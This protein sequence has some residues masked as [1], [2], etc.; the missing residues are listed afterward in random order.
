MARKI[1]SVEEQDFIKKN[2][3][4]MTIRKI[5]E[6]LGVD[7]EKTN[8]KIQHM[9][10]TNQLNIGKRRRK[11]KIGWKKYEPYIIKNYKNMTWAEMAK[12]LKL[13]YVTLYK[14]AEMMK[15]Q[16]KIGSKEQG[17]SQL[18]KP[19]RLSLQIAELDGN[20]ELGR[21]Y[22]IEK[23]KTAEKFDIKK[24]VG[25]LIQI[26]DRFYVFQNNARTESFLKIDFII[27][28]YSIKEV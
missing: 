22:H 4:K 15:K 8:Q 28:E 19:T 23:L 14:H 9:K 2:H 17:T 11:I 26:T 6:S 7:Y 1:W 20:M 12:K 3:G 16:G 18:I 5:S 27:G 25:K 21:K 10:K 13:K 24:F